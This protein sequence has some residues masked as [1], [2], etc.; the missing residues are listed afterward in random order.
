MISSTT[1]CSAEG[2]DDLAVML[3]TDYADA[4]QRAVQAKDSR[5]A[6]MMAITHLKS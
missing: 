4:L 5:S 6:P 3:T 2:Q 1:A